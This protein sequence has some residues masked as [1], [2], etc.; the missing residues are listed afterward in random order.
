MSLERFLLWIFK[1]ADKM[2][3]ERYFIT[4]SAKK[5]S[6]T[7]SGNTPISI[8]KKVL[9]NKDVR[10]VEKIIK[11]HLKYETLTITNISYLGVDVM[12]KKDFTEGEQVTDA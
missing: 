5:G 4:F 2:L 3:I 11:Q 10:N 12:L 7:Y 6:K 9:S 1:G 8:T